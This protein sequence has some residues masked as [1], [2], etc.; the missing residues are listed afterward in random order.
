M[1]RGH[2]VFRASP[3][4]VVLGKSGEAPGSATTPSESFNGKFRDECLNASWFASLADAIRA[5]DV[6]RLDY[7]R[8]RPHSALG[9]LTPE[10][11]A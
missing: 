8:N 11:F 3:Q 4:I 10:E 2:S 6:R 7:N 9:G 5:I 1:R